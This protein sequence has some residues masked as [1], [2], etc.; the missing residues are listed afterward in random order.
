MDQIDIDSLIDHLP[1]RL[2]ALLNLRAA[3]RSAPIAVA[4]LPAP[5]VICELRQLLTAHIA[6]SDHQAETRLLADARNGTRAARRALDRSSPSSFAVIDDK[7]DSALISASACLDAAGE[8]GRYHGY[9][10]DGLRN[11]FRA[12]S[13]SKE[14]F[15]DDLAL[16]DEGLDIFHRALWPHRIEG[17]P[18]TWA[19]GDAMGWGGMPGRDFWVDWYLRILDGRAQNWPLLREIAQ[20]DDVVWQ[21]GG[22][23]LD[24]DMARIAERYRLLAEARRLKSG[25]VEAISAPPPDHLHRGHNHPPELLP[26]VEQDLHA[27][28]VT[29]IA[30]LD[31]VED[32]LQTPEISPSRLRRIGLAIRD[33]AAAIASYCAGLGDAVLKEAAKNVGASI[34]KWAGPAVVLYLAAQTPRI[35]E[36]A[37]ALM[38]FAAR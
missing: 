11:A 2:S 13:G 6:L 31:E 32:A 27:A 9:A 29:I 4:G 17:D 19:R 26:E 18:I 25:L 28:S 35:Q 23:A 24:A 3:L 20:I 22:A 15:E 36:F 7:A 5:L 37:E 10:S 12:L 33:A 21:Q 1:T 34:G 38:S 8:T 16:L 14:G 30:Q